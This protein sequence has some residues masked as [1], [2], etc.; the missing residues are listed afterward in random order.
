MTFIFK[1][2]REKHYHTFVICVKKCIP[3]LFLTTEYDSFHFLWKLTLI[4]RSIETEKLISS[5]P[6]YRFV[7]TYSKGNWQKW[8][9]HIPFLHWSKPTATWEKSWTVQ[10]IYDDVRL[11][12]PYEKTWLFILANTL[13]YDNNNLVN[14]T[15]FLQSIYFINLLKERCQY[16]MGHVFFLQC[17]HLRSSMNH[18]Q[19][20][21]I[22]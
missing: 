1:L 19:K 15:C 5:G 9:L 13:M 3:Y 22:V 18:K 20:H 16:N 4:H 2:C 11:K 7:E 8:N 10:N 17:D 6:I 12:F 14:L 21:F